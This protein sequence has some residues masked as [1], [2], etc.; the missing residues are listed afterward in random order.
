MLG[1]QESKSDKQRSNPLDPKGRTIRNH[2]YLL[3]VCG[4]FVLLCLLTMRVERRKDYGLTRMHRLWAGNSPFAT[5]DS[6]TIRSEELSREFDLT[7][8]DIDR[9]QF[10]VESY[11]N[12]L[13]AESPY[14]LERIFSV[15]VG[16]YRYYIGWVIIL[17]LFLAVL[18]G[19]SVYFWDQIR[20]AQLHITS[21]EVRHRKL[22]EELEAKVK[23]SVAI[24]DK[25]NRLQSRFFETRKL[26]SIGRLSATLAHEIRN[27]LTIINSSMDIVAE[28]AEKDSS[29]EAAVNL[30]R[31]EVE[32]MDKILT[33]LLS[34]A[35]PKVP[36]LEKHSLRELV[37]HW[38]PPV[39]EEL[40]KSEIQL[41]PQLEKFDT[42]VR[43]DADQ[44]YQ[45]FLNIVWNAR[46]ALTGVGNPHI[47]VTLEEGGDKYARLIIQD[48]G[49]G[50]VPETL[51][52]IREPFF[53]TKTQGTG[54]GLPVSIQLVESMGGRLYI[55]SEVE[56][57]TTVD[58]YLPRADVSIPQNTSEDIPLF[59]LLDHDDGQVPPHKPAIL[60]EFDEAGEK[61]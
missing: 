5:I 32:R 43:V 53:T 27:P 55:K 42:K 57:G 41:V 39:V 52:Q 30:I 18:T 6:M 4:V 31:A 19:A 44:L 9:A 20:T 36:Q 38:L 21:Q 23:E 47:F 8:E 61:H 13:E 16:D 15:T 25:L 12:K 29:A 1:R 10:V 59:H 2:R 17:D 14:T 28:D 35:R 60:E 11:L 45:V 50:M 26:A 33:E 54:L 58:I 51:E 7:S 56:Y 49:P 34:Y 22:N 24:I 40:E 48:T 37:R 46:D 3:V